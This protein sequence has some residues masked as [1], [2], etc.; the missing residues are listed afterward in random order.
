VAS[1]LVVAVLWDPRVH[2]GALDSSNVTTIIERVVN[3][4]FSFGPI[5]RVLYV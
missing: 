5:L 1:F 2:V 3:E 4:K